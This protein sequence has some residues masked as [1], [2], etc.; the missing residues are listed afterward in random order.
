LI[1]YIGIKETKNRLVMI[2]Y[3][4]SE[5]LNSFRDMSSKPENIH[6]ILLRIKI[7]KK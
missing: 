4:L 1:Q 3:K 5:F 6:A 7:I 2:K